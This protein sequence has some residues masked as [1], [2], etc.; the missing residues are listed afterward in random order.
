MTG[1]RWCRPAPRASAGRWFDGLPR[2]FWVLWAGILINRLGTLVEPFLGVYLVAVRGFPATAAGAVLAVYAL[3][4]MVSQ[5]LGGALADTLGRSATLTAGMLAN[6]AALIALGYV[7][8]EPA[9]IAMTFAAGATI[10]MYRP[11]ARALVA[12]QIPATGRARAYGLISWAANLG[13]SAA[14][15]SG[16]ML[17]QAGFRWLFWA[18]ALTCAAFAALAWRALP[19][20]PARAAAPATQ[21][22]RFAGV[23]R[24]RVIAAF[25]LVVLGQMIVYQQGFTTLPI[26]M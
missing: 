1:A 25:M 10:D 16:G 17:A 14:M 3:G 26:A 7:T 20:A 22:R 23:L 2:L 13:F 15:L 4:S 12:D 11:A 19:A 9:V 8:A 24:D 5:I 18:D 6:G 21:P